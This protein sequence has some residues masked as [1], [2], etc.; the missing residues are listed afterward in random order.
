MPASGSGDI[1]IS[2]PQN[3]HAARNTRAAVPAIRKA[4]LAGGA[5]GYLL[6]STYPIANPSLASPIRL[7]F[8]TVVAQL[9]SRCG[10]WPNDLASGSST[11]GWEN[12]PYWNFGCASQQMLAAQV[13]DPRDLLSPTAE[14]PADSK[15]RA[16]GIEAIRQGKDPGTQWATQNSNIGGVGN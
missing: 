15:M 11:E 6:I 2:L 1:A 9:R 13:A 4:L 5:R 10:Q 7:S 14:T 8:A 3:A 16:R 12:K